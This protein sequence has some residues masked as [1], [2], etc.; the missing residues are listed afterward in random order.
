MVV[1][2]LGPLAGRE[3]WVCLVV[4]GREAAEVRVDIEVDVPVEAHFKVFL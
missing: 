1:G 3:L 4:L 2:I